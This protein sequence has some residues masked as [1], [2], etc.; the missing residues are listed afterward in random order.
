MYEW[1]VWA[2]L[3]CLIVVV[4]LVGFIEAQPPAILTAPQRQVTLTMEAQP[5]AEVTLYYRVKASNAWRVADSVRVSSGQRFE[6]S[7][8]L[9]TTAVYRVEPPD[10]VIVG[11]SID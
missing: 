5:D 9:D 8:H 1:I 7:A 4:L 10:T 2:G 6:V 3:A 11:M